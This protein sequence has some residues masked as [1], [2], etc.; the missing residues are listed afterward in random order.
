MH[1]QVS[2]PQEPIPAPL[3]PAATRCMRACSRADHGLAE[4]L[5]ARSS[6]TNARSHKH[7]AARL[8]RR[9]A[10]AADSAAYL[11]EEAR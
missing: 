6:G 8:K 9:G 11:A 7:R 4:A 2:T 5:R 3:P 1:H 10:I